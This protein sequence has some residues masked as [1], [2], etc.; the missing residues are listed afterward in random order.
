MKAETYFKL[1]N[2]YYKKGNLE[3]AIE[4]Y[5]KSLCI[6]PLSTPTINN[7]GLSYKA[8]GQFGK[9]I[10]YFK[11][12][13]K[14]D[15]TDVSSYNNLGLAFKEKKD[16]KKAISVFKEGMKIDS[17]NPDV[18]HNLSICYIK[19]DNSLL[20]L[21]IVKN[22]KKAIE[23][24]PSYI[25]SY[26]LLA[27]I[28][29]SLSFWNCDLEKKHYLATPDFYWSKIIEIIAQ[30]PE[31]CESKEVGET[32]NKVYISSFDKV[33]RIFVI[34]ENKNRKILKDEKLIT[35]LLNEELKIANQNDF[36]LPHT[37]AIRKSPGNDDSYV[38]LIDF[39]NGNTLLEQIKNSHLQLE[40]ILTNTIKFLSFIHDKLKPD[41]FNLKR[42]DCLEHI[43]NKLKS[44]N[45]GGL[46]DK[47]INNLNPVL[48]SFDDSNWVFNK[49]AHP[50]NWIILKDKRI[51]AID[52][53]NKGLVPAEFD[54]ANLLDYLP[55]FSDKE[56]DILIKKYNEF[57]NSTKISR[58]NYLNAVVY[59]GFC[60]Y[61]EWS[62]PKRK[63]MYSKRE[64]ILKNINRAVKRIKKEEASYYKK[65][66]NNYDNLEYILRNLKKFN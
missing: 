45:L 53:E 62:S 56:K 43:K 13:M 14:L 22:L 37:S 47:L 51:C 6:N 63:A 19:R 10:K 28:S 38:Y 34:K 57:S 21:E 58:L 9:A 26:C 30:N 15:P 4:F 16:Y 11:K 54:L 46:E 65:H 36:V 55:H 2:K 18:Y 31:L 17:K 1:G 3:K 41:K 29:E 44:Y 25:P 20:N 52:F 66:K 8:K 7:L 32:K 23:V 33:N 48:E 35:S 12:S 50:E 49:D 59:R 64:E 39:I 40:Q 42:I 60:L 24:N 27:K 5:N 61:L